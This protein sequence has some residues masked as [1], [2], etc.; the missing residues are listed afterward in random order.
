MGG[1]WG[2]L[3]ILGGVLPSFPSLL[4]TRPQQWRTLSK[5][6]LFRLRYR[7]NPCLT[8]DETGWRRGGVRDWGHVI[9]ISCPTPH[10]PLPPPSPPQSFDFPTAR[11]II[12]NTLDR[13]YF[14]RKKNLYQIEIVAHL[15]GLWFYFRSGPPPNFVEFE[16]KKRSHLGRVHRK[17]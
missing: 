8:R 6:N 11:N 4:H 15:R 13:I 1:I 12:Y 9:M 3:P 2:D 7:A 10:P 17:R 16:K 5:K 14:I